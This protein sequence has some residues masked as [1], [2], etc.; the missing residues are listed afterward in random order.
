MNPIDRWNS[1]SCFCALINCVRLLVRFSNFCDKISDINNLGR[2]DLFWL[3]VSEVSGHYG[4]KGIV[5]Q[6]SSHHGSK[7]AEK[8]RYT[9]RG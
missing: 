1:H 5:E 9:R 4:R 6:N 8:E 2:K 7:E 3:V